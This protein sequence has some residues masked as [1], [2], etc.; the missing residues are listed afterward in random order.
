MS[1]RSGAA[2]GMV[3]L[4]LRRTGERSSRPPPTSRSA[5]RRSSR[6]SIPSTL[7]L[8]SAFER[9]S[10][11]PARDD[12]LADSV[13]GELISSEI[14]IRSGKGEDFGD[15]LD[16]QRER[17]RRLFALAA[18]RAWRS[19]RP[20]RIRGARGRSSASSTRP[21]TGA[22]R[23]GSST[24]PGATTPSATT[25]TSACAAPTA[26]SPSATRCARCCPTLLAASA[27][28]AWVEGVFSGLHSART[29]IFTRMFPRCGVPDHFGG[30][31][32]YADYVEF[33]FRDQLD[34]RAHPDLVERPAAP[35]V[36]H[37]RAADHG[38]AVARAENRR[39][40]WRSRRPASRRRRSTTTP[41]AGS[42]P[43]PR[44]LI[45]ENVWRAIRYGLD[46]KLIDL[47]AGE[48]IPAARGGRAADG[49]DRAGARA[50]CGSTR[51]WARSARCSRRATAPS[52]SGA[53]TR[54]ASRCA[55][56]LRR[57]R[58][59]DVRHLCRGGRGA[60]GAVRTRPMSH[61][62]EHGDP[63]RRASR[64]RRSCVPSSRR[65]CGRSRSRTCCSRRW[66]A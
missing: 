56:D 32:A 1:S 29:E 34:R 28:S 16:R 8:S 44:R 11:Q 13:A 18:A 22:S 37:R 20:A 55:D 46:G 33:L 45:E 3:D 23:R 5:S 64:A 7:V 40:C 41:A 57:D 60:G 48:E 52:G 26:P 51:T 42:E 36:R 66:S 47:D 2:E 12:V 9:L 4:R 27:N 17:R 59:G 35:L 19:A 25:S 15:A 39:R 61:E 24:S 54:P 30:W 43:V 63:A 50:S 62:H 49:V 10:R 6:C 58:R 21:T 31:R 38:R 14:E 65:S 53:R